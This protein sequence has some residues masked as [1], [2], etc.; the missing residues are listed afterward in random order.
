MWCKDI[1]EEMEDGTGCTEGLF[2]LFSNSNRLRVS[3]SFFVKDSMPSPTENELTSVFIISS[4]I[5]I[6]S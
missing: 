3:D 2:P 5:P 6:N 1:N 4:P